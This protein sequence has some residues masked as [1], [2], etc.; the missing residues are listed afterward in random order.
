MNCSIFVR[1]EV[2]GDVVAVHGNV[3]IEQ[4]AQVAGDVTTIL[5]NLRLQGIAKVGGEAEA[6]GGTVRSDPQ[7]TIGGEV[8]SLGGTGWAILIFLLPL[9]FIG[10][11]AALV[12]WLVTRRRRPMPIAA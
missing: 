12:A 3:V 11:I 2:A 6:V 9:A 1:G 4:G 10:G 5:G 8:T 7:A